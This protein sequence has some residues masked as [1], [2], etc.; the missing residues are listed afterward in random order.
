MTFHMQIDSD[1]GW[2]LAQGMLPSDYWHRNM[3]VEFMED[4]I[5]IQLRD[6]IGVDNMIWGND[7]PHAESTWPQSEAFLNRLFAKTTE[8]ERRKI[9]SENAAKLFQFEVD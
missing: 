1:Q 9:T 4:E 5:G 8:E 3:F 7:F 6:S 2:R